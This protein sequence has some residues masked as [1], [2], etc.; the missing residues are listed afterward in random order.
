MVLLNPSTVKMPWF[1]L[2]L[3]L[4]LSLFVVQSAAE[5]ADSWE[6]VVHKEHLIHIGHSHFFGITKCPF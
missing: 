6:F 3:N 2:A 5:R 4:S 1:A